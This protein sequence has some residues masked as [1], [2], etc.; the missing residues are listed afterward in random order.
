M[1]ADLKS[2]PAD[3]MRGAS[4]WVAAPLH[5]RD[6]SSDPRPSALSFSGREEWPVRRPASKQKR[7][8][9][10][11][12]FGAFRLALVDSDYLR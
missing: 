8:E 9:E 2:D 11:M 12:L 3:K 1:N 6:R 4:S 10:R 5:P 7:A